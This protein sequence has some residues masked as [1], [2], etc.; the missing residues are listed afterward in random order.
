MSGRIA[1]CSGRAAASHSRTPAWLQPSTNAFLEG[2]GRRKQPNRKLARPRLRAS[3]QPRRHS[4]IMPDTRQ[5]RAGIGR[6]VTSVQVSCPGRRHGARGAQSRSAIEQLS[7]DVADHTPAAGSGTGL[8]PDGGQAAGEHPG[9][10]AGFAALREQ[11]RRRHRPTHRHHRI[12]DR[13]PGGARQRCVAGEVRRGDRRALRRRRE[14]RGDVL[15][16]GSHRPHP[17]PRLLAHQTRGRSRV[18]NVCPDP[19]LPRRLRRS[20]GF[21][22][23]S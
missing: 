9:A 3:G 18:S 1:T 7:V 19:R 20:G 17:P 14:L 11:R 6:H 4:M 12:P 10:A 15:G 5:Q 2:A 23:R 22:D 16:P 21:T 8:G 13:R